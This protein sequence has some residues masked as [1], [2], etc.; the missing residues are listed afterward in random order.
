MVPPDLSAFHEFG[1]SR[2]GLYRIVWKLVRITRPAAKPCGMSLLEGTEVYGRA[3]D[4]LARMA[5]RLPADGRRWISTLSPGEVLVV[6]NILDLEGVEFFLARWR[7]MA[8]EQASATAVWGVPKPDA[9]RS[10]G[11]NG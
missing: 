8:D 11:R 5:S 2:R 3:R 10:S 4:M 1:S 7:E 9:A 6:G